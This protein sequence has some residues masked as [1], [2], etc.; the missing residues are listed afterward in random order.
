MVIFHSYVK[1][2]EG[3]LS[4]KGWCRPCRFAGPWTDGPTPGHCKRYQRDRHETKASCVS[5]AGRNELFGSKITCIQKLHI[6]YLCHQKTKYSDCLICSLIGSLIHCRSLDPYPF[7]QQELWMLII[8]SIDLACFSKEKVPTFPWLPKDHISWFT[9]TF[10]LLEPS[11]LLTKSISSP[12]KI[13]ENRKI[14]LKPPNPM[15]KNSP[16]VLPFFHPK[17][18]SSVTGITIFS[19]GGTK[20]SS[21]ARHGWRA[22]GTPIGW[23][24]AR[25]LAA[26]HGAKGN[27]PSPGR[28]FSG[29][30]LGKT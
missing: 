29:E 27:S 3:K 25:S 6:K 23:C 4:K 26:G 14:P 2:P 8:S 16:V 15:K 7:N 10:S 13:H 9:H 12:F 21:P 30:N 1:L 17:K 5:R 19:Q 24:P 22:P 28:K 18:T 20:R 11:F